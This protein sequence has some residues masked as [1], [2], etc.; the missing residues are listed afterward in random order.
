[1]GGRGSGSSR[2]GG[3][4]PEGGGIRVTTNDGT[5]FEYRDRGNGYITSFTDVSEKSVGGLTVNQIAE[6]MKKSGASVEIFSKSQLNAMERKAETISQG[7]ADYEYAYNTARKN[8][9][10]AKLASKGV[11]RRR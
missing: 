4:V 8:A 9:R 7:R 11:R 5:I 6:R 3:K 2:S 10:A 1:M